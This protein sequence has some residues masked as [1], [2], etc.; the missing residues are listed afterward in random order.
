MGLWAGTD[1]TKPDHIS[2]WDDSYGFGI[3]TN[4]LNIISNENI[5][6]I[7][8]LQEITT[9]SSVGYIINKPT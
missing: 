7:A 6:Q 9:T 8:G 5:N 4:S 2:L 1:P 3:T